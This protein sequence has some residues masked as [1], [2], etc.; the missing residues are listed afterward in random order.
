VTGFV[1][2]S[3]DIDALDSVHLDIL[4]ASFPATYPGALTT[5]PSG[6]L[7]AADTE[8]VVSIVAADTSD[9][10]DGLP[11]SA[12]L[13]LDTRARIIQQWRR[14][15]VRA[16]WGD[17]TRGGLGGM[18]PQRIRCMLPV[19]SGN[20]LPY[21]LSIRN[22]IAVQAGQTRRVWLC[23]MTP[24][25]SIESIIAVWEWTDADGAAMTTKAPTSLPAAISGYEQSAPS[26][27]WDAYVDAA[28][29]VEG[30]IPAR[31]RLA[32]LGARSN[33]ADDRISAAAIAGSADEW[34]P[35]AIILWGP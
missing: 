29:I 5:L 3:G 10:D 4:E 23:K 7:Q 8:T 11:V 15:K 33:E 27:G 12:D 14:R 13:L 9:A 18:A 35:T 2:L 30:A 24:G 6:V 20:A 22:E 32:L 16:V 34:W 1:R 28:L 17:G 25:N 21:S 19:S 26:V 31:D